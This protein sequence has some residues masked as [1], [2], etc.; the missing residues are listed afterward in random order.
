MKKVPAEQQRQQGHH[1]LQR[2]LL[3]T[4]SSR[5]AGAGL[6]P[7][8]LCDGIDGGTCLQQQLHHPDVVLLAGDM[9]GCEAILQTE[10]WTV[11]CE[12]TLPLPCPSPACPSSLTRARELGLAPFSTSSLATRWCPQC[13]ATCSGVRWSRVMSS[14]S[15]LYCRSRRTQSRWSPCAAMWIGD[16]PFCDR[17]A[18]PQGWARKG[19]RH[20]TQPLPR[21]PGH[22]SGAEE[23]ACSPGCYQ[24]G[25]LK[26]L[27]ETYRGAMLSKGQGLKSCC[28]GAGCPQAIP[29]SGLVPSKHA[30]LRQRAPARAKEEVRKLD[31]LAGQK[32]SP[33][34]A[35]GGIQQLC[36]A[37]HPPVL[38]W[39]LAPSTTAQSPMGTLVLA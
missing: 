32:L 33:S 28:H 36:T 13:A 29:F 27:T 16:K 8:Y 23:M 19:T 25:A 20:P 9:E 2:R 6:Q 10:R 34:P 39:D 24:R 18:G 31:P 15:A 22:S 26:S 3:C 11:I 4:G 30:A 12:N 1:P 17:G 7:T 37:C 38:P 21:S 14:I 5:R 35:M